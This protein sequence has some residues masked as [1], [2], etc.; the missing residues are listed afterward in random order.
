MKDIEEG[1][2]TLG[3]AVGTSTSD[4][5][6]MSTGEGYRDLTKALKERKFLG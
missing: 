5:D 2:G 1:G 4:I 3:F 6:G